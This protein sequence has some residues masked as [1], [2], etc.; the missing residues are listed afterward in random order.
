LRGGP[1]Q[2][3]RKV[4][5]KVKVLMANGTPSPPTP[6][7]KNAVVVRTRKTSLQTNVGWRN[8]IEYMGDTGERF[9]AATKEATK[10]FSDLS[11]GKIDQPKT[12]QQYVDELNTKYNLDGEGREGT[13]EKHML[14][15]QTIRRLVSS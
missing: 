11:L 2:F 12:Q 7:Q 6:M 14:A 15:V 1:T 5:A 13:R 8:K 10:I 3:E 4:M 9:K